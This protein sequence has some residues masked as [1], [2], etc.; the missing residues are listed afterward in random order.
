MCGGG[1]EGDPLPGRGGGRGGVGLGERG[2][3]LVGEHGVEHV[4]GQEEVGVAR[5]EELVGGDAGN[6]APHGEA[7]GVA[8]ELARVVEHELRRAHRPRQPRHRAVRVDHLGR[9][10]CRRRAAASA[11]GRQGYARRVVPH[12]RQPS[13][14]DQDSGDQRRDRGEGQADADATRCRCQSW[15]RQ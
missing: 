4:H 3:L 14:G 12:G 1:G 11:R 2:H 6:A 9:R 5:P 7:A 13:T 10:R 15:R 8:D